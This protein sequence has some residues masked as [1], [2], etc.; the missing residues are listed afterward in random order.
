MAEV[1]ILPEHAY[2]SATY[3]TEPVGSMRY[4]LKQWTKGSR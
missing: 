4:I 1:G 2:D 3:G